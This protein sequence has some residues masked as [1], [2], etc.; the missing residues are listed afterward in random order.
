MRHPRWTAA[1]SVASVARTISVENTTTEQVLSKKR[2]V[3]GDLHM[4]TVHSD[5]DW[6]VSSLMDAAV[7]AELDFIAITDHNTYS[8]HLRSI[9]ENDATDSTSH[10]WRR[11]NDLR[12]TCK[13]MGITLWYSDRFSCHSR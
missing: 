2:W 5:G 6:T 1:I 7:A 13:F 12:R 11:D 4:H 8:H 10:S 9:S 3:S